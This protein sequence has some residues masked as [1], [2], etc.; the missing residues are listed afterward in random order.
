MKRVLSLALAACLA[1]LAL[2]VAAEERPGSFALKMTSLLPPVQAKP[3]ILRDGDVD[4]RAAAVQ[5]PVVSPSFGE[6]QDRLSPGQ[7]SPTVAQTAA[8]SFAELQGR[9]KINQTVYVRYLRPGDVAGGYGL[10]IKGRVL[11]L[12]GS[13]LRLSVDGQRREF[14]ERDVLVISERRKSRGKGALIGLAIGGG[15]GL[16]NLSK[17]CSGSDSDSCAN[18]TGALVGLAGLGAALGAA[19]APEHERILFLAPDLRQ[20]PRTLTMTPFIGSGRKG[21]TATV[22]F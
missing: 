16:L 3:Q 4:K 22:R 1:A 19:V 13:T 17:W 2:P 12:S 10:G 8:S 7:A 11:E 9:L 5:K 20:Q 18:A 14:S 21:L 15:L 6:P